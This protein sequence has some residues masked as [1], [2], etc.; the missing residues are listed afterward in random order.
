ML[1]EKIFYMHI[2]DDKPQLKK[3]H[4]NGYYTQIQLAMGLAGVKFCDFIV[5]TFKGMIISRTAFDEEYFEKLVLK[6]NMFY[7][8]YMLP[9]LC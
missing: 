5:Y 1:R 3:T 4:G 8:Q 2:V 6:L 9:K 7:K